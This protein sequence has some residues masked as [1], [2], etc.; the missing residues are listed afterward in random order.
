MILTTHYLD[1]ADVLADHITIISVG[2]LKCE[3]SAV[4]LKDQFGG[5]YRV[6]LLN[7]TLGPKMDYPTK[8]IRGETVYNTTN[9]SDAAQLLTI[10]E[11]KGHS[12]VFVN[13]PTVEDVFLRIQEQPD[14]LDENNENKLMEDATPAN[15]SA[16]PSA[17]K[18]SSGKDTSFSQQCGIMIRKRFTIL[19]RNWLPYFFALAVPIAITPAIYTFIKTYQAPGCS[20]GA[21]IEFNKAQPLSLQYV[22]QHIGNLQLLVGPTSINKT[23]YDVVSTF[24]I[25]YGLSLTNY[26]NQVVFEDNFISFEDHIS[27]R[28]SNVTPGGLYMD[29][30]ISIPTYAYVSDFGIL[31]AMVMQNLYTQ[32]E[33]SIPVAAYYTTFDKLI[34]VSNKIRALNRQY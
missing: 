31:P 30:N 13:G 34:P 14:P 6:H 33:S 27:N 3:G 18:L 32:L 25:G 5:G 7:N 8:Q 2:V 4:E 1:E 15:S 11:N 26:T 9:S 19:L 17:L 23:L 20:G 22:F 16:Q 28:Y 24:P 21:Y 12:N 29:S 10:L